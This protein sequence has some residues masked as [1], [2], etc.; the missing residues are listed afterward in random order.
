MPF[1]SSA[2][3]KKTFYKGKHSAFPNLFYLFILNIFDPFPRLLH[4]LSHAAQ[5][6]ECPAHEAAASLPRKA[7]SRGR[8]A[9]A[10]SV[11]H[12]SGPAPP[13]RLPQ[14][15]GPGP[16]SAAPPPALPPPGPARP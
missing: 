9:G 4:Y 11:A 3:F 10:G 7:P 14:Q 5:A 16:A 15:L 8:P 12:P 6:E 13:G 2:R 1:H